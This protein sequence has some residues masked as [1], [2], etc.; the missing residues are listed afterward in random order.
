MLL[1]QGTSPRVLRVCADPNNLPFSNQAGEGFENRIAELAAKDVGASLD[2]VWWAQRRGFVRNTLRAGDCDAIMGVPAHYE[3]TLNTHPYYRSTYAVVA[4]AGGPALRSIDDP[5]LRRLKVGVQM[6]GNDFSNTPPAH[7]LANRGIVDNVVG[8]TVYG[9]YRQPNPAGR[10]VAAVAEGEVD[11]AIVWGPFAGYFA[12]RQNE[13]LTVTE[14]VEPGDGPD[15]PFAFSIAMG[16]AKGNTALRD[17]LDRFI[18]RR[19]PEIRALLAQYRIPL[20]ET[21]K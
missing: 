18:E 17:E 2:Y 9:D 16:V 5:A 11:V 14:L 12:P 19:A 20:V 6:I 10:I 13:K 21:A 8:Y 15:L 4:R 7:A 3:L 1:L